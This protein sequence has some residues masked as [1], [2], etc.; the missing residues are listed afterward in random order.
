[1]HRRFLSAD[2]AGHAIESKS[3]LPA[4]ACSH[5]L[6][7]CATS[8]C[9]RARSRST[10]AHCRCCGRRPRRPTPI[11]YLDADF[12]DPT[13]IRAPDGFLLRLCD[14]VRARRQDGQYP[15]RALERPR[16]L[17]ISRRRAAGQAGVGGARRRISGRPTCS[18]TATL[19]HVLFGQ[20]R[21]RAEGRQARAVPGGRH[22]VIARGAVHR[23]RPAAPVRRGLRQ[24][25]PDGVRRPG[26]R[27]APALLGLGL[28]ADQGA[29]AR[30][31]TTCRSR[32]AASRWTWSGRT[33]SRTRVSGAGRRRLGDPPRRLLLLVLLGRQLLR[34]QGAIT[35]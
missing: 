22:R 26:D 23:H 31:P 35:R 5:K 2:G 34:A 17:A 13:V 25:R 27:Q 6:R 12:P 32:R 10:P 33:R 30:P 7:Q 18:A 15:G 11:P 1:M 3:L 28:P 29:G 9:S 21:R 16:R 20:A 24:H 19:L 8:S 14:A 4:G